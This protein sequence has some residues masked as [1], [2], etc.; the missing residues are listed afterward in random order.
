MQNHQVS[1]NGGN[2]KSTFS[3]SLSYFT[4]EG[5][6]GG[7]KSQFDR[8][9]ARLNSTHKVNKIFT[10]GNNLAYTHLIKRGIGTNQSFNGAYS[11]ALNLDP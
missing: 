2:D 8:Y 6:I 11:S 9:T 5:I 10:F 7:S 3:S 1:V 4:Q